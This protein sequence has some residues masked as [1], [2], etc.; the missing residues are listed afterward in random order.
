LFSSKTP[1][2]ILQQVNK[3]THLE[4]EK[5][6]IQFV[7]LFQILEVG[8]PMVEYEKRKS[9]YSFLGVL[10]NPKM[11]WF[12]SYGWVLAEFM[13]AQVTNKIF[14][15]VSYSNYVALTCDEVNTIDNMS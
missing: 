4:L 8:H 10:K 15:I 13:Y 7:T 5:K 6:T 11:Q 3:N 1:T 9:L 2:I 12:N 14:K